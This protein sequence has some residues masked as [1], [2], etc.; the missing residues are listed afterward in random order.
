MPHDLPPERSPDP[1]ASSL[2][3]DARRRHWRHT[4]RWTGLL[5]ALWFVV[6]FGSTFFARSLQFSLFGW[7]FGFWI[8]AQG[9]LLVYLL[10]VAGYAW[11]MGRLER[12][13]VPRGSH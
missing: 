12:R 7:P 1:A 6:S 9:A 10:I 4:R 5:L 8:A 2:D 11:W 3:G 13:L